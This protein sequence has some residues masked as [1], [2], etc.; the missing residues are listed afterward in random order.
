MIDDSFIPMGLD[1]VGY[2]SFQWLTVKM[3]NGKNPTLTRQ[4]LRLSL[5]KSLNI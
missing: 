3:V 4:F 2:H 1:W 5:D